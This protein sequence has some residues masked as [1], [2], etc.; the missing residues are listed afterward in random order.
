MWPVHPGAGA[1]LDGFKGCT[2]SPPDGI[3]ERIGSC[4]HRR[5]EARR[6]NG[7]RMGAPGRSSGLRMCP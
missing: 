7:C 2:E 1:L 4:R 6:A 3:A 5:R